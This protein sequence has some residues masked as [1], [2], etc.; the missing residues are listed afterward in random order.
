MTNL[1]HT[2]P[3]Q[4]LNTG[5]NFD[6]DAAVFADRL[7]D[8]PNGQSTQELP[9]ESFPA[10]TAMPETADRLTSVT[11]SLATS[12]EPVQ[13]LPRDEGREK[14]LVQVAPVNAADRVRLG[15][16][17]QA[18]LSPMT[19]GLLSKGSYDLGPYT[20]AVW[21]QGPDLTDVCV[22]SVIAIT[23]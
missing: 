20:G 1:E 15:G 14:L 11:L 2:Q 19:S 17:R 5:D 4:G 18:V 22:V 10:V 8:N 13:I 6:D 3:E 7:H 23:K 21:L 9:R 16:D 12:W